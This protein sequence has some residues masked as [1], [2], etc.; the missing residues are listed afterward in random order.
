VA[1]LRQRRGEVIVLR[2]VGLG[3]VVQARARSAELV[4][5]GLVALTVGAAA[6]WWVARFVVGGLAAATLTGI[7]AAPPARFVLETGGTG[8]VLAAAVAGLVLVAAG[9]GARVAGQA[10]DT[11]YREEVR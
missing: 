1:T 10:R 5:V 4:S 6:G 9:V 8:L 2:A 11:T 7:D 3:P